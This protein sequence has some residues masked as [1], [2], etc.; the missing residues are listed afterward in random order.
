MEDAEAMIAACRDA[1]VTL[2]VGHVLRFFPQ[3]EAAHRAVKSG[4]IGSPSI[5]RTFRGNGFPQGWSGWY[6]D[7][8]MSGGLILDMLLHDFDWLVWTFGPV[9]RVYAK[10]LVR[11]I[12]KGRDYAL[13][14]VRHKNGVIA[15]L[16]G[17]W[18][19]TTPFNMKLEVAGDKGLIDYDDSKAR[20]VQ[21]TPRDTGPSDKPKVAIP[22]SPLAED[23]YYTELRHFIDV[24]KGQVEPRVT[25]EDAKEVLR[26]ALAALESAKTGRAIVL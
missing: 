18:S 11:D 19:H 8:E 13:V 1:G 23:P 16:E 5:A 12:A 4:A 24:M 17:T 26:V 3:Y 25:A 14:T 6:A 2:L 15:H 21:F 20:P 7:P 10:G 9:E 22:E